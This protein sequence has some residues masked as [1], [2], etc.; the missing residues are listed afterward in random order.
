MIGSILI[1][2]DTNENSEVGLQFGVDLSAKLGCHLQGL[3]IVDEP[4]ILK[5]QAKPLG[6][7]GFSDRSKE[8][9][10]K[11][12]F[13]QIDSFQKK[14]ETSAKSKGVQNSFQRRT[15][16]PD[17]EILAEL[18]YS[19]LLILGSNTNY[20]FATQREDCDTFTHVTH[21]STRPVI[22]IPKSAKLSGFEE[23]VIA[24][25]GSPASQKSIQMF[26][27]SGLAKVYKKITVISA[28]KDLSHAQK[29]V[30]DTEEYMKRHKLA[31]IQKPIQAKDTAWE[32]VIGYL[33][34]HN[35]GLLVMGIYGTGGIKEFFVGSFTSELL[36]NSKV[37]M[38]TSR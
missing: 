20:K 36:K 16:S 34:E 4:E 17:Q 11:E 24:T 6:A 38:F 25:D 8:T 31:I 37:P 18:S 22:V 12:S 29:V 28:A 32:P 30:Q 9:V 27:L 33:K 13:D 3:G 15:G 7:S 10:L 35:P 5:T 21:G 2:L 1:P 14:F 19:D 26:V 23:A